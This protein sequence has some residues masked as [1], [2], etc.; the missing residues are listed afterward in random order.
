LFEVFPIGH[1]ASSCFSNFA[2]NGNLSVQADAQLPALTSVGGYLSVQADAQLP[3]LT[4]VGGDLSV[5]IG[6]SFDHSCIEFG[7]GR[8][9]AIHE[10]ALHVKEGQYRAGCRG[11]WSAEQALKHWNIG[12]HAPTRAEKFRAAIEAQEAAGATHE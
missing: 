6:T 10:Y 4:S 12:H 1:G 11:P 9:L 5:A 8:V 7:A 2:L 3:A